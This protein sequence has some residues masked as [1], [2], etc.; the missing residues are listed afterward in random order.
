[1][2]IRNQGDTDLIA[3]ILR[4]DGSGFSQLSLSADRTNLAT[5]VD[6]VATHRGG[7]PGI[8]PPGARSEIVLYGR[9]NSIGD[10]SFRLAVGRHPDTPIDWQSLEA[11]L[12]PN[13]ISDNDWQQLF[14]GMQQL[15]GSTWTQYQDAISNAANLLPASLGDNR[16]LD[17]VFGLLLKQAFDAVTTSVRGQLFLRD[18]T[19]PLGNI[20]FELVDPSDDPQA[21]FSGVS[22]ADGSFFVSAVAPGDYELRFDGFTPTAPV[23][24]TVG[25]GDVNGINVILEPAA[26]ITGTVRRDILGTPV[27]GIM[28]IATSEAGEIA[29]AISDHHGN[30]KIVGLRGDIYRVEAGSEEFT[31]GT[32]DGID[33]SIGSNVGNVNLVVQP[34]AITTGNVS[35]PGGPVIGAVVEAFGA[36]ESVFTAITDENG[37]YAIGSLTGQAYQIEVRADG[38]FTPSTANINAATGQTVPGVDFVMQQAGELEIH[39]TLASDASIAGG[40]FVEISGNGFHQTIQTDDSGVVTH[41]Q[42][43]PG[44]YTITAFRDDLMDRTLNTSVGAG[45]NT[46]VTITMSPFGTVSG[47]AIDQDTGDPLDGIP[48]YIVDA[49]GLFLSVLTDENGNYELNRLAAGSGQVRVGQVGTAP[50]AVSP[51]DFSPGSATA[52]ADFSLPVAGVIEGRILA[53]DGATPIPLSGVRLIGAEGPLVSGQSNADGFYRFVILQEGDYQV[54]ATSPGLAFTSLDVTVSGGLLLADQDLVAGDSVLSGTVRD[55]ALKA[56][57][58]AAVEIEQLDQREDGTLISVIATDSTGRFE[59]VGATPG[60]YSI[61]VRAAGNGDS[62]RDR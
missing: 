8:L 25:D 33:V 6:L 21:V 2:S 27:R 5:S 39:T 10:E 44:D 32:V 57:E 19:R 53:A 58:A 22:L 4:V 47:T 43:P 46:P 24:V 55:A 35:G 49:E 7:V 34:A 15:V 30:F 18:F 3:P 52:S 60:Q 51:F 45:A 54:I 28:V 62:T 59:F 11:I 20:R 56:V 29:S 41:G 16:S 38:L 23:T 9:S 14:T 31:R 37:D 40:V 13:G 42:V 17:D 48:I 1:M 50:L 36:D 12:R 26:A 61:T